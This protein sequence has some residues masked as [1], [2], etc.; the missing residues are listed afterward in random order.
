M[1]GRVPWRITRL[2]ACERGLSSPFVVLAT[3]MQHLI[4]AEIR[5]IH[6][7][8]AIWTQENLVG[9]RSTLSGMRKFLCHWLRRVMR[10]GG[11]FSEFSGR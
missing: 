6:L 10:D 4:V 5:N 7:A 8:S 3:Q 1:Q 9:V 11:V 2:E